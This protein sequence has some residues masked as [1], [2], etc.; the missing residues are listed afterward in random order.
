MARPGGEFPMARGNG[1]CQ[2]WGQRKAENSGSSSHL[3]QQ[4][5]YGCGS[6]NPPAVIIRQ[7]RAFFVREAHVRCIRPADLELRIS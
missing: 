3:G 5:G 2:R 6:Y 7:R 4:G 1:E